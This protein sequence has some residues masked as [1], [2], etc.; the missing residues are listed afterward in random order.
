MSRVDCYI[1]VV[2]L[3]EGCED[4][5]VRFE[6]G[7]ETVKALNALLESQV[8]LVECFSGSFA[9]ESGGTQAMEADV[10]L[11]SGNCHPPDKVSWAM[12]H[13]KWKD[14]DQ[15]QLMHKGPSDAKFVDVNWR[16]PLNE[17]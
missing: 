5:S 8:H 14:P 11:Y 16:A 3:E 1:L 12:Q 2:G 13:V 15:V 6:R 10:F 7:C 17:E 9:E 4:G